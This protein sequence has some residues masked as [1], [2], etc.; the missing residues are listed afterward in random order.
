MLLRAVMVEVDSDPGPSGRARVVVVKA[1]E[2]LDGEHRSCAALDLAPLRP[3]PLLRGGGRGVRGSPPARPRPPGHVR[4]RPSRGGRTA[5]AVDAQV[6]AWYRGVDREVFYAAAC[7]AIDKAVEGCNNPRA[8]RRAE[9]KAIL[10]TPETFGLITRTR[11]GLPLPESLRKEFSDHHTYAPHAPNLS[12]PCGTDPMSVP[13]TIMMKAYMSQCAPAIGSELT[14]LYQT[15]A[16][17]EL[18]VDTAFEFVLQPFGVGEMHR[19]AAAGM[20][21]IAASLREE[22]A[23]PAKYYLSAAVTMIATCGGKTV[24]GALVGSRAGPGGAAVGGTVAAIG[25]FTT[26]LSAGAFVL[27]SR[28]ALS[29]ELFAMAR[30]K[31][32]EA[33]KQMDSAAAALAGE[34]QFA[35]NPLDE[36]LK[37]K[38]GRGGTLSNSEGLLKCP[39]GPPAEPG[40]NGKWKQWLELER[41]PHAILETG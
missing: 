25:G 8:R 24:H 6:P 7:R 14:E 30:E 40:M 17:V 29:N 18:C 33:R 26:S 10:Q 35:L 11:G 39:L 16:A 12:D 31:D 37:R 41:R 32:H 15:E 13:N 20:L 36:C 4:V 23:I 22:A 28:H 9:R 21:R 19:K 34:L 38:E 3:G 2:V 5:D 1:A 27:Q